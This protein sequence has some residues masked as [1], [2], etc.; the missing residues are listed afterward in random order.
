MLRLYVL[1][2]LPSGKQSCQPV[3]V[4][5]FSCC[6]WLRFALQL[7]YVGFLKR[8]A[9]FFSQFQHAGSRYVPWLTSHFCIVWKAFVDAVSTVMDAVFLYV[10]SFLLR[11]Q[12]F[13]AS[14]L[15]FD[16]SSSNRFVS[17]YAI[18][19]TTNQVETFFV[20]LSLLGGLCSHIVPTIASY[21]LNLF[22]IQEVLLYCSWWFCVNF[23]F[24]D[25]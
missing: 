10:W 24:H 4:L 6:F 2:F 5:V 18:A 3:Y 19:R 16:M 12:R 11:R 15:T 14:F 22:W 8:Y 20:I 21:A 23:Y 17:E 9:M 25:Y 7:I 13:R 1:S